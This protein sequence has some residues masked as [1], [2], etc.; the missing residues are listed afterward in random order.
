MG[1]GG[2]ITEEQLSQAHETELAE[3]LSAWPTFR[4]VVLATAMSVKDSHW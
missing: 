3:A 4:L 2:D 1:P